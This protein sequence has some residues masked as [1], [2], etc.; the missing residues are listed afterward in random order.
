MNRIISN[1]SFPR[2]IILS[3]DPDEKNYSLNLTSFKKYFQG[4]LKE[5][6]APQDAVE[7][8]TEKLRRLVEKRKE[9]FVDKGRK[10]KP[11]KA[12]VVKPEKPTPLKILRKEDSELKRRVRIEHKEKITKQ[13]SDITGESGEK[14]EALFKRFV[15]KRKSS[16]SDSLAIKKTIDEYN[17]LK[18]PEV[19]EK[20]VPT[21]DDIRKYYE[22][23]RNLEPENIKNNFEEFKKYILRGMT[24]TQAF[25]K[26]KYIISARNFM[27]ENN[28]PVTA[29]NT[30]IFLV[31]DGDFELA[32]KRIKEREESGKLGLDVNKLQGSNDYTNDY[33]IYNGERI[34][35]FRLFHSLF[36]GKVHEKQYIVL[37]AALKRQIFDEG[38]SV[39]EAMEVVY[40][41][42]KIMNFRSQLRIEFPEDPSYAEDILESYYIDDNMSFEDALEAT[43]KDLRPSS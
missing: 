7:I 31:S 38:K 32:A 10:T 20:E 39:D 3:I 23:I 24:L 13:L 11:R 33:V 34:S 6:I 41:I 30:K 29:T 36:Y 28:I 14:L 35:L 4:A 26:I 37:Y 17:R 18:E 15:I 43:K 16:D 22:L 25:N 42:L 19:E 40:K 21:V 9:V 12:P 8:A 2:N 27:R 5:G 1:E